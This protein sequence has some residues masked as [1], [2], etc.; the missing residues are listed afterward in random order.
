MKQINF[1]KNDELQGTVVDLTHEGS[2]VVKIDDYPF[3]LKA[4]YQEKT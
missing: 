3:S 4:H 1:N 2:G